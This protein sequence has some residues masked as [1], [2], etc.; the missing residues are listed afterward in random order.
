MSAVDEKCLAEFD[1]YLLDMGIKVPR[2]RDMENMRLMERE[3]RRRYIKMGPRLSIG[4]CITS[5]IITKHDV[6]PL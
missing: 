6:E 1:I 4:S 2:V 5:Y 3:R